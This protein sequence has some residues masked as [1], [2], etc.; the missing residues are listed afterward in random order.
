MKQPIKWHEGMLEHRKKF[1]EHE[2][3]NLERQRLVFERRE[4][5]VAFYDLQVKTAKA[6]NKDGFDEDKFLVKK[7]K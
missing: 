2:R 5:E 6:N 1:I 3:Q 7:K 4:R